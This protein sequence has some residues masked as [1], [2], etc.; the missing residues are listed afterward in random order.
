MD[1]IKDIIDKK[2]KV[3]RGDIRNKS[4]V[5]TACKDVEIIF[6]YAAD[7]DV[8]NS[9]KDPITSFMINVSGTL[10]ILETMRKMDI[11]QIIFAS[12]GGTVYGDVDIKNIP[13][14][15]NTQFLPIS[16]YGA[17]KASCETYLSAYGGSY[18]FKIIILRFANIYGPPSNHGVIYDFYHKLKQN[19]NELEILGNGKQEKSY[20]YISDCTDATLL[21]YKYL[22]QGFNA[23]NIGAEK[24]TTVDEIANV[25]IQEMSLKNVKF[26]YTGGEQGW[27]GD[28]KK[29]L[30]AIN[31]LKDLGWKP[32][33]TLKEGIHRYIEWLRKL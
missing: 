32:K 26:K 10:N 8:R 22:K 17:S 13:T 6:H 7:P 30:I 23:F 20:L 31:K 33:I 14:P 12:S 21:L 25:V 15:E 9:V 24:L 2:V 29:S 5:E 27:I 28:V 3:I 1:N 4:D 18:Q 16:P 19:P 11:N